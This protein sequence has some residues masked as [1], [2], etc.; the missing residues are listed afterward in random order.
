MLRVGSALRAT[1]KEE[2]LSTLNGT[3]A[4]GCGI[5]RSLIIG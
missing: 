4:W 5:G 1:S 2:R 3:G